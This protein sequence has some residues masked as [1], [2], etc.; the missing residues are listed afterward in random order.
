MAQSENLYAPAHFSGEYAVRR[1]A[2]RR[3]LAPFT[4]SR[5]H[6]SRGGGEIFGSLSQRRR[7]NDD[8]MFLRFVCAHHWRHFRTADL[9]R[10]KSAA[11]ARVGYVAQKFCR[12]ERL[13]TARQ[14]SNISAKPRGVA[15]QT[16][17]HR[18]DALAGPSWGFQTTLNG[19]Q[20]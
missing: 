5:Q 18:I 4:A 19:A 12:H 1:L 9:R 15:G 16:L 13:P 10:A 20:Q 17:A 2:F 3:F 6:F 7:E 8:R 14:T 11:R